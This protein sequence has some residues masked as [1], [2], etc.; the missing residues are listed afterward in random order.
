MALE[1]I[2]LGATLTADDQPFVQATGRARDALGR[3]IKTGDR[4][5]PTMTR[6]GNSVQAATAKMAA[7]AKKI[8]AGVN[9]LATGLR[10]AS[11]GML[12]VTAAI[13][14]GVMKAAN[15]EKQMSAVGAITR[16]N[17]SDMADLTKE[18]K[19]MG[20]VSVFS[21]TQAGEGMEYLAR[22]GANSNQI[23]AALQ[24]TMNAAAADSI[25]LAEASDIVAQIVKGM[26]LEW[27]KASHVA[28]VLALASARSNTNIM[29]LGES[30]K[31]GVSQAKALGISLEETTAIF[32]KLAD[33]GLKGSL[34][35]TSFT[36]M[37][38]KL[39]KPSREGTKIMK[40]WNISLNNADG[41]LR[42]VS[43]IVGQVTK[44]M[45][46]VKNAS[47]KARIASELFGIRGARAYNA[48]ATAGA[49]SLNKLE[50]ELIAASAGVGA[51]TE[52][53]NT[54]LDNFL[55][56]LTLFGAS[57]ESISIGIF[58][59]LLKTFTPVIEKVTS[60]L[61]NV[62][63]SLEGLNEIRQRENQE[64]A[65][66]AQ[67]MAAEASRRMEL[68]GIAEKQTNQVKGALQVLS[69]MRIGEEKLSSA[70]VEARKR[71]LQSAVDAE[72]QRR[73]EMIKTRQ[74]EAAGVKS[75]DQ[76]GE[77]RKKMVLQQIAE[78]T[79]SRKEAASAQ[80]DAAFRGGKGAAEAQNQLRNQ[81]LQ[82][83]LATGK[84]LS[85][86]RKRQIEEEIAKGMELQAVEAGR[87]DKLRAQI[88]ELETLQNIEK[89]HGKVAL[90]M[91]LGIQDA[92][93]ALKNAW[94]TVLG[95]IKQVGEALR[96][97][98]GDEG[99]RRIT[100]I[101]TIVGIAAGAIAPL[102][103]ALTMVGFT[104]SGLATAF[105][106]IGT[107]ASGVFTFISGAAGL[108]AAAFWPI[109]VVAGVL[110]LAF[111]MVRKEGESI[112]E[113]FTRVWGMVKT[114]A[115]NL[116]HNVLIPFIQGFR[117]AWETNFGEVA[118]TFIQTWNTVVAAFTEVIG[119]IKQEFGKMLA[120]WGYGTT[121]M[122]VNWVEMGKTVANVI[123][124]VMVAAVQ[125]IGWMTTHGAKNM[126]I[127]W[128][129]LKAPFVAFDRFLK[130]TFDGILD[131]MEGNFL[132]GIAKIATAIFDTLTS[133]LRL[134]LKGVIALADMIPGVKG[135]IPAGLK[136][137]VEKGVG[138]MV[139]PKTFE[140]T[141]K[142]T[143]AVKTA[144][145]AAAEQAKSVT[146]GVKVQSLQAKSGA[147][148][149][150]SLKSAVAA[151]GDL[152]AREKA[153]AAERPE[154]KAEVKLEDRRTLDIKNQMCVDGES[155]N[156]ASARHKQEIQD[157]AG[158]KS[159]PWQRRTMLEHGA[160]PV[161]GV[162]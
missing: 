1:R 21:A 39:S 149:I 38:N 34:A 130:L 7:G 161:K 96:A 142:A 43:D 114:G 118:N 19:R 13:G 4:V 93:D 128:N 116:Y 49:A 138:G 55:G 145:S 98:F 61:N 23:I 46:G 17:E 126:L 101:I 50:D 107:I 95:K 52:M 151:I 81:I 57:V 18:A 32:G 87:S 42:K 71:A 127:L 66:S 82:E 135:K 104:L 109:A 140:V 97:R 59:P 129:I 51:A 160:A 99:V 111:M 8:G 159:T 158:F 153:K 85:E 103:L 146:S 141:P 37:M 124:A 69:R 22:A 36:N 74:L 11:L 16:A 14:A 102:I 73:A 133:P 84:N 72:T 29:G 136:D 15:F 112:G 79:K 125:I 30:F 44:R 35:G 152:K 139:W 155:I 150:A 45:A 113:T 144:Q 26:G 3:F 123:M 100:K 5:P 60:G 120:E 27:G 58:G 63:F 94:D 162:A 89:K 90:Q 77:A 48:L 64:N 105:G 9:Q 110:V 88:F 53:A 132:R 134:A 119:I 78:M 91:A 54:R 68:V 131:I 20:I 75:M 106:A 154:V 62:L 147:D 80:I 156:V 67:L 143:G 92:I 6:M 28:D 33:A 76:L 86:A 31:Y 148:Q 10:N 24:G 65:K 25:G 70:Q 122:T 117:Q 12:P 115:L 47:E 83:T 108:V 157:R 137:F 121:D 40:K 41:T 2:G 56:R